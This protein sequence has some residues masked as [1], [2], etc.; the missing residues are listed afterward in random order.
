[1]RAKTVATFRRE[2][3]ETV[4]AAIE[5][6]GDEAFTVS[7]L[8]SALSEKV[9]VITGIVAHF[10]RTGFVEHTGWITVLN[11]RN[12]RDAIMTYTWTGKTGPV[13]ILHKADWETKRYQ[14]FR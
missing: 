6:F 14:E 8:A 5:A 9:P 7:D 1:M 3:Q 11:S 2:R 12:V 13:P 4:L 10:I